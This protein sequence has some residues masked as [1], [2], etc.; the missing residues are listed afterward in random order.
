[1]GALNQFWLLLW[2]NVIFRTRYPAVVLVELLWPVLIIGLVSIMRSGIPP[3][4]YKD[5]HY[6]GRSMVSEGVVPFL[7]SFV[8]NLDNH[9]FTKEEMLRE[10]EQN[11]RSFS[12][13]TQELSPIFGSNDTLNILTMS[14][15]S[16]GVFKSIKKMIKDKKLLTGLERITY[17]NSYFRDESKVKDILVNQFHILS[18][19]E[20][21]A[22][23]NSKINVAKLL[24]LTG[25][26]ELKSIACNPNQLESYILF[27]PDSDVKTISASL[28]AL[29]ESNISSLSNK[30]I[31][32]LNI[33]AILRAIK[34]IEQVKETFDTNTI[35]SIVFEDVAQLFDIIM[36]SES[37]IEVIGNFAGIPHIEDLIRKIPFWIKSFNNFNDAMVTVR[38]IVSSIQPLMV[39]LKLENTTAWLAVKNVVTMGVNIVELSEGRWN[40]SSEEFV[41]PITDLVNNI[42]NLSKENTG[43]IAMAVL[44]FASKID[45]IAVYDEITKTRTLSSR[46]I[47]SMTEAF[48][49]MMEKLPCWPVVKKIAI[50]LSHGVDIVTIVTEKSIELRQAM[51]HLFD[52]NEVLVKDLNKIFEYG[53]KVVKALLEGL[54]DHNLLSDL[55][56]HSTSYKSVCERITAQLEN[57]TDI[58]NVS[59]DIHDILCADTVTNAFV[60]LTDKLKLTELRD[61]INDTVNDI[62]LLYKGELFDR[63]VNLT[64]T[65][66]EVDKF[67]NDLEKYRNDSWKDIFSSFNVKSFN[68]HQESWDIVTDML[69]TDFLT[70]GLFSAYKAFGEVLAN[71]EFADDAAPYVNMVSRLVSLGYN[72]MVDITEVHP[73]DLPFLKALDLL[74]SYMPELVK[75]INDLWK[76]NINDIYN[77]ISAKDSFSRFCAGDFMAKLNL[78]AYVPV[79][80][81]TR[82]I[83][84]TNWTVA[85]K[86]VSKPFNNLISRIYQLKDTFTIQPA[87]SYN[88]ETDWLVILDIADKL[89]DRFSSDHIKEFD[90]TMGFKIYFEHLNFTRLGSGFDALFQELRHINTGD[91]EKLTNVTFKV[92]EKLDSL[93]SYDYMWKEVKKIIWLL[94][95]YLDVQINMTQEFE[96]AKTLEDFIK[97]YP[98][99]IRNAVNLLAKAYPEFVSAL[100]NILLDPSK[101]IDKFLTDGFQAPDCKS[102]FVTDY[103]LVTSQSPLYAFE[104]YFCDLDYQQLLNNVNDYQPSVKIFSEKLVQVINGS[105]N[106]VSVDWN[107]LSAKADIC[108]EQLS[109]IADSPIF[110][111]SGF[112]YFPFNL[113]AINLSWEEFYKAAKTLEH[114]D[115]NKFQSI[116]LKVQELALK[117][118]TN[119]TN[120]DLTFGIHSYMFVT[121][122]FLQ[123]ANTELAYFNASSEVV[124]SQYLW[125]NEL[126]KLIELMVKSPDINAIVAATVQCL[127]ISPGDIIVPSNF[128]D[129]CSDVTLFS[130]VFAVEATTLSPKVI[131]STVCNLNLNFSLM[132]DQIENNKPS[133]KLFVDA[134]KLLSSSNVTEQDLEVNVNS[135]SRDYE[136]LSSLIQDIVADPPNIKLTPNQD[137]MNLTLY[138][139]SWDKFVQ[140]LDVLKADLQDNN[141]LLDWE[142]SLLKLLLTSLEKFPAT[143]PALKYIDEILSL[144]E[145]QLDLN[146]EGTNVL[147]NYTNVNRVLNLIRS[148]PEAIQTILYT[149][150]MDPIKTTK[151]ADAFQSWN[152]FCST[153]ANEILTVPPSLDFSMSDFLHEMCRIDVEDLVQELKKY[154]GV[155]KLQL[156]F[157][158][159]DAISDVN[160]T[161]LLGRAHSYLQNFMDYIKDGPKSNDKTFGRLV[162]ETL[163]VEVGDRI[164]QWSHSFEKTYLTPDKIAGIVLEIVDIVF[165]KTPQDYK[166]MY[167]KVVGV[168]DIILGQVLKILNT[169]TLSE[170]FSD[171]PRLKTLVNLVEDLPELYEA[172]L[173][174]S[175]YHP[176]KITS[177]LSNFKSFEYFC[178]DN[179]EDLF[180]SAPN[181]SFDMKHWF[182]QLCSVN[183]TLLVEDL[184]NYTV[185]K[186]I[187][188]IINSPYTGT[189]NISALIDKMEKIVSRFDHGFNITE[190]IF[191]ADVWTQSVDHIN[192]WIW[193]FNSANEFLQD[194]PNRWMKAVLAYFD[195]SPNLS[196]IL[197]YIDAVLDFVMHQV[198]EVKDGM[199][200]LQNYTNGK[201]LVEMIS[202]APDVVQTV[203][204]TVMTEPI[205][206]ARWGVVFQ[207]WSVFCNTDADE[208]MTVPPGVNFNMSDFLWKVCNIDFVELGK[209]VSQNNGADK[210]TELIS[211]NISSGYRNTSL[212]L[213]KFDKIITMVTDITTYG[214]E[215]D[216]FTQLIN[217]TLW[218]EV[219][220]RVK[221]WSKSSEKIYSDPDNLVGLTLEMLDAVFGRMGKQIEMAFDKVVGI[222]DLVLGQ[223][224]DILN[225]T[226]LKDALKD[227]PS[228]Q[229]LAELLQNAPELFETAL[230]TCIYQPE[231]ITA[232]ASD[233]TSLETFCLNNPQDIFVLAPNSSLD[234]KTWFTRFCSL[235]ITKVVEELENYKVTKEI[236]NIINASSAQPV[237]MSSVIDKME[238]VIAKFN[239]G[240]SVKD[241]VFNPDIWKGV[242]D[243]VNTWIWPYNNVI[244]FM[245]DVPQRAMKAVLAYFEHMPGSSKAVQYIDAILDIVGNRIELAHVNLPEAFQEFPTLR[246]I[247]EL[248]QESPEIIETVVYTVL[249]QPVQTARWVNAF[250]SFSTFCSTKATDLLTTA[251]GSDL[252]VN[253]LLRKICSIQIENIGSE[254]TSYQG[255]NRIRNIESGNTTYT[256]NVSTL[257]NKSDQVFKSLSYYYDHPLSLATFNL[258]VF[259]ETVW[260]DMGVRIQNWSKSTSN[261]YLNA[262][263]ISQMF[264]LIFGSL[265]DMSPELKDAYDK[266]VSIT[267]ILVDEVSIIINASSLTEAYH[268]VT[269]IRHLIN[270]ANQ[271]PDLL[272]TLLYTSM[273]HPEKVARRALSLVSFDK[274]CSVD[275]LE[276]FTLPPGSNFNLQNWIHELCSLNFS[277]IESELANYTTVQAIE[278][279]VNGVSHTNVSLTSVVDRMEKII[280]KL[281]Q[282]FKFDERLW[283]G[284]LWTRVISRLESWIKDY[285]IYD[286][287]LMNF[288][289]I[290][291]LIEQLIDSGPGVEA[292]LKPIL[293]VGVILD[294]L[295]DTVLTLENKTHFGAVD[296]VNG[297]TAMQK[298][299]NIVQMPGVLDVIFSSATSEHFL[300]LFINTST[301]NDFCNASTP[302]T[303]YLVQPANVY[304]DLQLLKAKIC[305]IDFKNFM[306]TF[307]NFFDTKKLERVIHDTEK[308]NWTQLE[309][310][311]KHVT[312]LIIDQWMVSTPKFD[313]PEHLT[314]VTYWTS[315]FENSMTSLADRLQM[316]DQIEN[317][318]HQLSPLLK[319]EGLKETGIVLNTVLDILNENIKAMTGSTFTLGNAIDT[320]PALNDIFVAL[321]VDYN[322]MESLLLAPIQNLTK[323]V[324]LF[325]SKD[326]KGDFCSE[327]KWK[328]VFYLPDSFNTSGLYLSVCNE[329][330]TPLLNKLK[331]VYNIQSMLDALHDNRSH[332][333]DWDLAVDKVFTLVDNMKNLLNNPP[334]VSEDET[335]ELL[336]R[337]Y[338]NTSNLWDMLKALSALHQAFIN[339]SAYTGPFEGVFRVA[340]VLV[341]YLD[342]MVAR[343][344]VQS[345]R[346]DLVSLFKESPEFVNVVNKFLDMKPDPLTGLFSVQLRPTAVDKFINIVQS[347]SELKQLTCSRSKFL[348]IFEVRSDIADIQSL[349]T[350]LCN[351]DYDSI[352]E[353]LK[354]TFHV[355]TIGNDVTSAWSSKDSF[356]VENFI[357][358]MQDLIDRITNLTKVNYVYFGEHDLGNVLMINAT[359]LL[360]ELKAQYSNI[361]SI[362]TEEYISLSAS[363]LNSLLKRFNNVTDMK[364]MTL[365]LQFAQAY[366]HSLN[367]FL[368]SLK[369]QPISLVTLLNNTEIGRILNPILTDPHALDGLVNATVNARE[370]SNLLQQPDSSQL[371]CTDQLWKAIQITGETQPF[372]TLQEKAC[373]TN[374]TLLLW[375]TVMLQ[376][377][378]YNLYKQIDVLKQEIDQGQSSLNASAV[379]TEMKE[380]VSLMD[381]IIKQ[382]KNGSRSIN[383]LLDVKGFQEVLNEVQRT[384][385]QKLM[386]SAKNWSV[387][388][389]DLMLPQVM[390]PKSLLSV[391]KTVNSVNLFMN[392]FIDKLQGIRNGTISTTTLF[393]NAD[394]LANII[395]AYISVGRNIA[396]AWL[397]NEFNLSKTLSLFVN[398]TSSLESLCKQPD[399]LSKLITDN[400]I[401]SQTVKDFST[402]VCSVVTE[403]LQNNVLTFIQKDYIA[404]QL[405][406]IWTAQQLSPNFTEFSSNVEEFTTII[407]ELA[408]KSLTISSNLSKNFTF[409]SIL[410]VLKGLA[411]DP[412][413]IF[414][415]LKLLGIVVEAP[416]HKDQNVVQ[417]LADINTF[418]IMPF[419]DVLQALQ[420]KGITLQTLNSSPETM[421]DVLSTF[422]DFDVHYSVMETVFLKSQLNY[423]ISVRDRQSMCNSSSYISY[424]STV[425]LDQVELPIP[426]RNIFSGL[427][428]SAPNA[429]TMLQSLKDMKL[430]KVQIAVVL[431]KMF[432]ISQI[433]DLPNMYDHNFGWINLMSSLEQLSDLVTQAKMDQSN[434]NSMKSAWENVR[435]IVFDKSLKSVLSYLNLIENKV[436]FDDGWI[437]FK[438]FLR[439][440]SSTLNL[441]DGSMA[442]FANGKVIELKD[443]LPSSDRVA[444]LIETVFGGDAAEL[445]TTSVNPD[446]FYRLTIRDEW[447]NVCKV[448]TTLDYYFHF[449]SGTNVTAVK[450]N[451]CKAVLSRS[452]SFQEL[453]SLFDAQ[454]MVKQLDMLIHNEYDATGHND[455]V[456]D[457]FYTSVMSIIHTAESLQS[458][459]LDFS[460]LDGWFTP[461][462]NKLHSFLQFENYRLTGMCNSVIRYLNHTE[463]F[464]KARKPL[465][466]VITGIN[467]LTD[468]T[469]LLPELDDLAC[470]LVDKPGI[471][472]V[473]L[474][475]RL[476]KLGIWEDLQK[477]IDQF[478]EPPSTTDC[479]NLVLDLSKLMERLN[480]TLR[481]DGLEV[482]KMTQCLDTA[483]EHFRTMLGSFTNTT[484]FLRDILGLLQMQEL[485][486]ILKDPNVTPMLDFILGTINSNEK[487]ILAMSDL[488]NDTMNV[489][490]FMG[491]IL[492]LSHSVIDAFINATVNSNGTNFLLQSVPDIVDTLCAP[493]KLS[494]VIS[495]PTDS[496]ISMSNLSSLLCDSKINFTAEY[497]QNA[498]KSASAISNLLIKPV[499]HIS[500]IIEELLPYLTEAVVEFSDI[501]K[502]ATAILPDISID[503]LKNNVEVIDKLMTN[504]SLR[505][506]S[507]SLD[508]IL[509][510][511]A[512]LVPATRKN[513]M[514]MSDVRKVVHGLLEL[515]ILRGFVVNEI[516]VRNLI[517]NPEGMIDYLMENFNFSDN[518]AQAILDA[519]FSS[520][521]L[522]GVTEK[523]QYSCNEVLKMLIIINGTTE[524][525]QNI[526]SEMCALS[527][528][529]LEKLMAAITPELNIGSFIAK[530]VENT[531]R[532]IL[533]ATN[534]TTEELNDMANKIDKGISNLQR[535][536]SLLEENKSGKMIMSELSNATASALT[537]NEILTQNACGRTVDNI[538]SFPS[539]PG[540]AVGDQDDLMEK[541]HQ[542]IQDSEKDLPGT[543]CKDVYYT[544]RSMEFGSIIWTY[545]K[546]IMRGKILYTPDNEITRAI[547]AKANDTFAVIEEVNRIANIWAQQSSN[548]QTMMDL[549]NDTNDLTDALKN[550]FI[551][552]IIEATSGIKSNTLLSSLLA[553]QNQTFSSKNIDTLQSAAEAIA[554]YTSCVLTDR[555]QPVADEAE[556]VK[557]AYQLSQTKTFFAGIVF[558]NVSDNDGSQNST[559][560]N[561]RQASGGTIPK[562]ISYKIRMDVDNVMDTSR[563]KESIFSMN[564]EANF[565]EDLRYLRGFIYIQDML[566]RAFI[567]IHKNQSLETPG[568]VIKQMPFPCHH[569]DSFI[570]LLGSYFVPIMMTFVFLIL[571][572]VATHNLV[573]DRE[574]GQDENLYVMGMIRGLS[575]IAW[576]VS[577]LVIMGIVCIIMA[578]MLKYTNIFIYSNV[579]IMFLMLLVF[580]FSSMMLLYMV[581]AFFTRTSMAILFV[582]MFYLMAYLPYILILGLELSLKFWHRILASLAST[583]A[584]CFGTLRISY[585]E[586]SGA[587]VQWSNIDQSVNDNIS[588]A[589][590]LYMM[591]ID[592]AIYFLIGWYVRRVKPGKYGVAQ[593]FYFILNPFY[594]TSCF[595]C[596]TST[597]EQRSDNPQTE[598]GLFEKPP[599]G[600]KV[601]IAIENV[602]KNYSSKK[603]ALINLSLNIYENQ[604][605]TLLGHNGAAKTTTIKII[606]GVIKPTS[607]HVFINGHE[608]G[609]CNTSLGVCPQ[610]NAL[611]DYMSVEQHMEFYAGVKSN[612]DRVVKLAE[613]NRLL[614]DVDLWHARNVPV[615]NLSYGMKRR[616]CVALAFVGGSKTIILDEPTSGVDP[617]ARKNIWNLITRNRPGR[618]ILLST[619][620][621]DEA[622]FLSDRIAV[623][624]QGKLLCCG[625]PSFLKWSIGGGYSLTVVKKEVE[626]S[627]ASNETQELI[628]LRSKSANAAILAFI[629]SLCPSATLVEQV[630]SDLTFNLSKDPNNMRVPFHQ[631]FRQLD[632]SV[633]QLNIASYGLSD[634]SLE[635]VF[636]KLTQDAD[637]AADTES[638]INPVLSHKDRA[639]PSDLRDAVDSGRSHSSVDLTKRKSGTS[640][641]FTQVSALLIKRFHHYRRNW[642]IIISSIFLPLL[643]LL[644]ALGFGSV[645][646][647]EGDPKELVLDPSIYGP[648]TYSF[649]Q[650]W[651]KTSGSNNYVNQLTSS[652]VGYGTACMKDG[653]RE[654]FKNLNCVGNKPWYNYSTEI[655]NVRCYDARQ[656]LTPMPEPYTMVEKNVQADNYIQDIRDWSISFYLMSTFNEY[657]QKRYGGWSFEKD[658]ETSQTD[659]YVWFN[660]KGYHAMPSYYNALTN[661]ILRAQLPSGENP[662]EYGIT[663]V[664]HPIRLD[665]AALNVKTLQGDAADAGL[666]I[667][668]VIAFS[669]IPCG[670]I[671]Y[672][673]NEKL[674]KEKQLQSIS[675][676]GIVTYWV[677]AFIWDLIVYTFTTA[678]AVAIVAIVKTDSFYLRE[679]LAG[680]CVILLLY[681]WAI[682]PCLYCL[683]HLFSKGSTAYLI[684]FCINLFLAMATVLSLLVM[685][686]YRDSDIVWSA[687]KVC[688]YLYL[689]FPQYSLGEG[690]MEMASNTIVYKLFLRFNDDK[691]ESPFSAD[692]LGWKMVAL[693]AEGF[694]FFLLNLLL[695][696]I[697]SPT[698]SL[699]Q[700]KTK[701]NYIQ[702]TE[703]EDV[704]RERERIQSGASNDML[705]VNNLSKVYKRNWKKFVAVNHI[706]FGVPEGECFGLLGVNGAGK[707]TTFRMLTG[708]SIPAGGEVTLKGK[709]LSYKDRSF[710]QNVGY[711]PQ[712]G[713]LD[714]YLTAEEMLCFH[715]RLRGFNSKQSKVIV[716]DLLEQLS[717]TQYKNSAV[718]TYSGGTKRKLALAIALLGNPPIVYLDEPTTGMDAATRRLAWKCIARANRNGQSVVLTSHSMDEC[719]SLCSTI[720]IMV[721]GEIKCIGSP[722]HLK[723][724]Y[725][726]GYTVVMHDEEKH[727]KD[728]TQDFMNRFPGTVIKAKNHN[729]VELSVPKSS[730]SV[731]DI[732]ACLQ[733]AQENKLI[734]YYSVSQTTLDSVFI[735]FAQEQSDD[736]QED[737]STRSSTTESKRASFSDTD[738]TSSN[739]YTATP[740]KDGKFI[741]SNP[742]FQSDEE[743]GMSPAEDYHQGNYAR[744]IQYGAGFENEADEYNT[745]F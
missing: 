446:M 203:L 243:H 78:P 52:T 595:R 176:E 21:D 561:R 409:T 247:L 466:L 241:R 612:A 407:K 60:T 476:I 163:W 613:I 148:A 450:Q 615:K 473:G 709:R 334:K 672:V 124:I 42:E 350:A 324:E 681:G 289:G 39:S 518:V 394:T 199:K 623:M 246:T 505:E 194:M 426:W 45:W 202:S 83:C 675:G 728:V 180:S 32:Q 23:F 107:Q 196:N 528:A 692:V 403:S 508:K 274:F 420:A 306:G 13:L 654:Y 596:R 282:D 371:L 464:E 664:T 114:F 207:S 390:D 591:L 157:E 22:L 286:S 79:D 634:T 495:L 122:Q 395:N 261:I 459:E 197:G 191:K 240:L 315:L 616:L 470:I 270:L 285:T 151:W 273:Y 648:K 116:A 111:N 379:A 87:G 57:N 59:K 298:L 160:V 103:M 212:V 482:D 210:L 740:K 726:D 640:L 307:D 184:C 550:D 604:I 295:L 161:V 338:T 662:N 719:D 51:K 108:I 268:N 490:N 169:T 134:M 356:D 36:N 319:M 130:K 231:K 328:Q 498:S 343:V 125:S 9:C 580:C 665:R 404:K 559:G 608:S 609:S 443:I 576:A 229:T 435:D 214:V 99:V 629:Q 402:V 102:Y 129:L 198:V 566:D 258:A 98:P 523:S 208:I 272:E 447:D 517:K 520:R 168:T 622:D 725:G 146:E 294:N 71:S 686:L 631:F 310:K 94:D 284:T 468:L 381:T 423:F 713:G 47:I 628:D 714:E 702:E 164:K 337:S 333:Q 565:I 652:D 132:L 357:T 62:T 250:Q 361:S 254:F 540:F 691:Y 366:L 689:I 469:K 552:G 705:I 330:L 732:L 513:N 568:I 50:V 104:K 734:G 592:S 477:A 701:L 317:I 658:S 588:V 17:I 275:P 717:L 463:G 309:L 708:D 100:R 397:N 179:P 8:C 706:S 93:Y 5:C 347:S 573:Y 636:L 314:N 574:N 128:E 461:I 375:Q 527:Y 529:Q 64:K 444:D 26:P 138:T 744:N 680:F 297:W 742:M 633:E 359:R 414:R 218:E 131:Q 374:Q 369:D 437:R 37:V 345:G 712:E 220:N 488:L 178:S 695:E 354:A 226:S 276:I 499:I 233:L 139:Q 465:S 249:T 224:I 187:E 316:K 584:L 710:G 457:A 217:I 88:L 16:T 256:L 185:A 491:H 542:D 606:S 329:N 321:G 215:A 549:A 355:N 718:H 401:P 607:G 221:L 150:L 703:D 377:N 745:K 68:F 684:T 699:P 516:R 575:F 563:L 299:I 288:D 362:F 372:R 112:D 113:T 548:L 411:S 235:N 598:G 700:R 266:A 12:A 346:L 7:Q 620:H 531:G 106:V 72:T 234:L 646:V 91:I 496:L 145:K 382:Y 621:L 171:L 597:G 532:D 85:V 535:A 460:T 46:T 553:V 201:L 451:L 481:S 564:A 225:S 410:D 74:A 69:N 92:L 267:S 679:N 244:D 731:A 140:K 741:F 697:R 674:M 358:K 427:C 190:R 155:D 90:F 344:K 738:S 353:K 269:V 614:R 494:G 458:L 436:H 144:L 30:I 14:N 149:V 503:V 96:N 4:K 236:N 67:V 514:I 711:C 581:S 238:T 626:S 28:C 696:A 119:G 449:P 418:A 422:L 578:I 730:R 521:M 739:E 467:L 332:I 637:D 453:L 27:P 367:T 493:S 193:P 408:S 386:N 327:A 735:S 462:I 6:Q 485:Q 618:T 1:M 501:I 666:S 263:I 442:K 95:A 147:L 478:F 189:I 162:N 248:V 610:H 429:D 736:Y 340:N 599:I 583:T 232:K 19:E 365:S 135:I 670:F 75:G 11:S 300:S 669:F 624:H 311:V 534:M 487:V 301:I 373:S 2:K 167:R 693:A 456:W 525:L 651:A 143:K 126:N 570:F 519:A 29:N 290:F 396:Q 227:L 415:M 165:G 349:L 480:A 619:H 638:I 325:L 61:V 647:S 265:I 223:V 475:N 66:L 438:Q 625:S 115:V 707:T 502:L 352:A 183:F 398:S 121:H 84:D 182:Q 454:D 177:K 545:L 611:F 392:L 673:L 283:N 509:D 255:F 237:K 653:P 363:L 110:T 58:K 40:R 389:A 216:V 656:V 413:L 489:T 277:T 721:N 474:M 645:R 380:F 569:A 296:I 15:K 3:V 192:K 25:Y 142:S 200:G 239:A 384:I 18:K 439:F 639:T 479:P 341:T 560:R 729:S 590:S 500:D 364:T 120:S 650:D 174:T 577:T 663:A 541:L 335:L 170:A 511:V 173:Y 368:T 65:Y 727:L 279:I 433:E 186:D 406:A 412:K 538:F 603:K 166:D 141:K 54:L 504:N 655:Y 497:L 659:P 586:E 308:L 181:S 536:Y 24:N 688:K 70:Q 105:A 271:A 544:I 351:L 175:I 172:A 109:S 291:Q 515:D 342:E 551:R 724:K 510:I 722:Q 323:F 419:V 440:F 320:I 313:L 136:T 118:M 158:N 512:K 278:N 205:K 694:L 641:W 617:H 587:G 432:P 557:S 539:A 80:N 391:A 667:V 431:D 304:V 687:Y 585:L 38:D 698:V 424:L 387:D 642:R 56:L 547:L 644:A 153:S 378:G 156:L 336:R 242:L 445:L 425:G 522:L 43:K 483:G 123:L 567:D 293:Y 331:Q 251:P 76:Y 49:D 430:T 133:V 492:G 281:Q 154:E 441:I 388:I 188:R 318:I 484:L 20:A 506:L 209:E 733:S 101:L 455:T 720:A 259:N 253:V 660:T 630:G 594:W 117:L 600:L 421:L 472:V 73:T 405:D 213:T 252:D 305:D 530:Y 416:L 434:V 715:A 222:T 704:I 676:I 417:V 605:T 632:Q 562:H 627:D 601:G 385:A 260:K 137:W 448:N 635:E 428:S 195:T 206:S 602:C 399:G 262:N 546:P 82:L 554:N 326:I 35:L 302:V 48:Q 86:Q 10:A 348:E 245:K 685:Q 556:L 643:F 682:L 668:I 127:L 723:H 526:T 204:Y 383:D 683:S 690:L 370:L 303:K 572:G 312:H 211:G 657:K 555:F 41:K 582:I 471:D 571:I 257:L 507:R 322:T 593:P 452:S 228:L 152:T 230:Y 533:R 81:I 77:L 280:Q 558:Y 33:S 649:I 537:S 486:K 543:F 339:D 97:L 716:Q 55:I 400:V 743:L 53:P 44:E 661:S 292:E 677:V 89:K 287:P 671:L 63:P 34:L 678:L 159:P 219:G 579:L 360:E 737:S 393:S 31:E 376:A 589:W 264:E 524:V